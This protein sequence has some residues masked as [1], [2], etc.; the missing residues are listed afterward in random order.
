M[1]GRIRS[2]TLEINISKI[3]I[4]TSSQSLKER[5]VSDDLD[6][7]V[8]GE[9]SNTSIWIFRFNSHRRKSKL[10]DHVIKNLKADSHAG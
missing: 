2:V 8:L 3:V 7:C 5:E 10:Q 4:V 1:K 6:V 9:N